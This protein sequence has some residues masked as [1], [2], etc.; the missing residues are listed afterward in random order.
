[1]H[2]IVGQP[3]LR[4]VAV[5]LPH[6]PDVVFINDGNIIQRTAAIGAGE[7]GYLPGKIVAGGVHGG[8]LQ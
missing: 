8:N 6:R 4:A 1:M 5:N 2:R 3:G 7:F